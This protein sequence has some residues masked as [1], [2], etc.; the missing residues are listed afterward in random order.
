MGY[1][2]VDN[3]KLLLPD[4]LLDLESNKTLDYL[5]NKLEKLAS[6]NLSKMTLG[7]NNEFVSD[8]YNKKDI[9][10]EEFIKVSKFYIEKLCYAYNQTEDHPNSHILTVLFKDNDNIYFTC[11]QLNN[12]KG[13]KLHKTKDNEIVLAES[14][15][16]PTSKA[17]IDEA[18]IIDMIN[19]NFYVIQKKFTLD[20]HKEF[21]MD[22]MLNGESSMTYKKALNF[23]KKSIIKVNN[24]YQLMEQPKVIGLINDY[25]EDKKYNFEDINLYDLANKVFEGDYQS[26][27]EIELILDDLGIREVEN[28]PYKLFN[29]D[30]SFVKILTDNDVELKVP[31]NTILD[32]TSIVLSDNKEVVSLTLKN[33]GELSAK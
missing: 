5:H 6:L 32:N 8:L 7:N 29:T 14:W 23:T 1:I 17:T 4:S 28:I 18:F 2:D 16:M 19:C 21:Y 3:R 33:V 15:E 10:D 24:I 26:Q 9:T 22:K 11:I 31:V 12:K 25:I 27:S 30:L 20:G 13:Y